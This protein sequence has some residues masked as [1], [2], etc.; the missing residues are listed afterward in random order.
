MLLPAAVVYFDDKRARKSSKFMNWRH[1]PRE[2]RG[3]QWVGPG[4]DEN[5]D[6]LFNRH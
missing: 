4:T 3:R 1:D 5:K 2:G 6:S